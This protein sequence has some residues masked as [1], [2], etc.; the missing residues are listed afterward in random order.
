MTEKELKN[1]RNNYIDQFQRARNSVKRLLEIEK[2][3]ENDNDLPRDMQEDLLG[4]IEQRTDEIYDY[5]R[6]E[7]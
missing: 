7:E 4:I 2:E 6:F 5:I 3:V 1:K